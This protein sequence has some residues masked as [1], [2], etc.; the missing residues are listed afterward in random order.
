MKKFFLFRREEDSI[1]SGESVSN[2]GEGVSTIAIAADSLSYMTTKLGGLEI[3]FN[4]TSAF[5]STFLRKGE[6]LPKT[7]IE[8]SC[9]EGEE[10]LLMESILNFIS[11][12][13]KKNVMRFDNVAR[14]STFSSFDDTKKPKVLVPTLA[15]ETSTGNVSEGSEEDQYQNQI[16]GINFFGNLPDIDFNHEGLSSFAQ[17]DTVSSWNNAGRL[18]SAYSISSVTSTPNCNDPDSASSGLNTKSVF[19]NLDEYMT[20][21]SYTAE[22][23]YTLYIVWSNEYSA[24][25][26][27]A[28]QAMYGDAAG[29]TTGPGGRFPYDGPAEKIKAE[30][31]R[32]SI[33]HSGV[34]DFP[35]TV[36]ASKAIPQSLQTHALEDIVP[37]NALVI[38]RDSFNNIYVY[39]GSGETVATLPSIGFDPGRSPNRGKLLI[40]RLGTTNEITTA[41][42]KFHKGSIARFGVI[43]SDP[44]ADFAA[45]LAQNLFK[46]YHKP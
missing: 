12:E 42:G 25:Y 31:G 38:R 9:K 28:F 29:E 21:P 43:S 41:L 39:D 34:T 11:S 23:D 33:R 13:S 27:P 19:F 2:S 16:A 18:G 15:V 46:L 30:N 1:A 7:K 5:E 6:S 20:V 40:E 22:E 35:N 24:F 8:V 45:T 17:D 10:T 32:I 4:G 36:K 3:V 14:N 37:C 44:G 26:N